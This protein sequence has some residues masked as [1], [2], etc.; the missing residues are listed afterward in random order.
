MRC[1]SLMFAAYAV[2]GLLAG[3][4]NDPNRLSSLGQ[5]QQIIADIG[6][7]STGPTAAQIRTNLTPQALAQ[8]GDAPIK[9]GTVETPLLSSILIGVG[10]NGAV[11]TFTTPDGVSFALNDGM[12]V[13][14]RGLGS[15]LM[16]A[17]VADSRRAIKA[18]GG[19]GIVRIHR[20][21]DG[22]EQIFVRSFVCDVTPDGQGGLRERCQGE[23]QAFENVYRLDAQGKIASSR[24]WISPERG[25]VVL[26]SVTQ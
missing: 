21:L 15:D 23:T 18:G 9:I 25:A 22:E 5:V 17:D 11:S 10:Q 19:A 1:K 2:F 8:F 20:Y 26:E 13:A 12:L 24:Q 16:T 6:E 7:P 4:G 14:T 3:C